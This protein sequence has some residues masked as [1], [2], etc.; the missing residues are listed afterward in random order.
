MGHMYIDMNPQQILF[1]SERKEEKL[2][3]FINGMVEKMMW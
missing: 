1:L 3:L 2:S